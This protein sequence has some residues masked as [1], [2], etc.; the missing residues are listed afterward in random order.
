MT[1][2][3]KALRIIAVFSRA[4][5]IIFKEDIITSVIQSLTKK[6]SI[7]TKQLKKQNII[8]IKLQHTVTFVKTKIRIVVPIRSKVQRVWPKTNIEL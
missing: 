6:Q 5:G 2:I 1:Y 3:C 7:N 8:K 4:K